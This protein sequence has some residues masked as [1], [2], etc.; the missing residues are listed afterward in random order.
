MNPRSTTHARQIIPGR[1][2]LVSTVGLLIFGGLLVLSF[3]AGAQGPSCQDLFRLPDPRLPHSE[4]LK[5]L[6]GL[7]ED[8]QNT[9][10]VVKEALQAEWQKRVQELSGAE[11]Q[12]L[13]GI[14]RTMGQAPKVDHDGSKDARQQQLNQ[15]K[16]GLGVFPSLDRVA[17]VRKV[18]QLAD[19]QGLG[20]L[21]HFENYDSERATFSIGVQFGVEADF[22]AIRTSPRAIS[23][24]VI[25]LRNG[26][27]REIPGKNGRLSLQGRS[28]AESSVNGHFTFIYD[29]GGRFSSY[30]VLGKVLP[31][32]WA[33]QDHAVFTVQSHG[34]GQGPKTKLYYYH[35]VDFLRRNQTY[36]VLSHYLG[37]EFVGARDEK[38]IFC[39]KNEKLKIF[40]IQKKEFM[41]APKAHLFTS[42]EFPKDPMGV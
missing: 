25:D 18:D 24:T 34:V 26:V 39:L 28:F 14:L 11:R 4:W 15:L 22:V 19:M 8:L 37:A 31:Y 33:F 5:D 9:E 7:R 23:T 30:S 20:F 10:G 36:E 6:A 41:D 2:A 35:T 13:M 38:L 29:L 32:R 27:S 21:D 1:S 17:V 40:D 12:D 3:T 16:S 42:I